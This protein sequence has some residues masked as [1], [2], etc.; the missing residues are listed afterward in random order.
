MTE[1]DEVIKAG[2]EV[3]V[4]VLDVSRDGKMSLSK[5]ILEPGGD[6]NRDSSRD[7]GRGRPDRG[8][9]RP[10]NDRGKRPNKRYN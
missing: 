3:K 1:I 5:K 10:R 9:G 2:D 6:T 8:R 7:R 4:K